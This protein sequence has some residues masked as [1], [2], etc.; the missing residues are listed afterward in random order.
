MMHHGK[1]STGVI[2]LLGIMALISTGLFLY[3]VITD[4]IESKKKSEEKD[5]KFKEYCKMNP[6]K[7]GCVRT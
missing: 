5:R 3:K 7:K 1:P 2:V 6:T 4:M